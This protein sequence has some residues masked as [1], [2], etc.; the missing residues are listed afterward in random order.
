MVD[1]STHYRAAFAIVLVLA[2]VLG[3]ANLLMGDLNQDEGWYVYAGLSV[4]DGKLP[5]R[6]FAFTQGPLLPLVYSLAAPVVEAFGLGG[7]R[8]VT[9]I[10]GF[11]SA[12]LAA[13]LCRR[14]GGPAAGVIVFALI[15]LNV[16]QS[17]FT[18]VVK[19]YAL[20]AV[21]M[22]AGFYALGR[23]IDSRRAFWIALAG[24]G[25][26][27]AAGTRLSSGV[28]LPLVG[29]W[30]MFQ[31]KRWG[32]WGWLWFGIGG[33]VTLLAVFLPLYIAAP[34]GFMFGL[35]EYHTLRKAGS[36]VYSMVLKAGFVSRLVQVYFVAAGLLVLL[37][38]AKWWRPFKGQ[39]TGYHQS[40]VFHFVRLL[41]CSAAAVTLVH[42]TAP[43]PYDDYQVPVF[44]VLAAAVA[45][46]WAYA[47]RAWST[48]PYRWQA[49][50]EPRDPAGMNWF[51]WGVVALCAAA[52]F[53]S[54]I[55]Q[56]WMIAGRD[57]IWWKMKPQPSLIQLRTVASDIRARHGD[58]PMLTQDTYLAVEA[59]MKVP[60]GWEMGP[61]SYYP[62]MSDERAAALHL[63]NHRKLLDDLANQPASVAAFSGY[64][65]SIAS[66]EV[67]PL[68]EARRAELESVVARRFELVREVPTFGQAGT[69]L[70]ILAPRTAGGEAP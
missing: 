1:R 43:F 36:F 32:R 63:V 31:P 4:A 10:F 44:P 51:V 65:L 68:D 9:W 16:Y 60:A 57:R 27:A 59:R 49:G 6:D 8:A 53:S 38:A 14:L 50:V 46:S 19:T 26:A 23:W 20:C 64:S 58:G 21:F 2:A 28:L 62:D 48:E 25:L 12:L 33:G 66:P 54:Q 3:A 13:R 67:L 15:A 11:L 56:D 70:R 40:D 52:A 17:Y 55:N 35:V 69:T 30:L 7:A 37:A 34:E 45:V 29:L 61:F 41:W 39:D 22:M 47:V 24:A 42:V 5:Y 18:T